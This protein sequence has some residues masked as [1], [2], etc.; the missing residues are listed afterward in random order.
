MANLFIVWHT[1]AR[2][3]ASQVPLRHAKNFFDTLVVLFSGL[4]TLRDHQRSAGD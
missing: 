3:Q 4:L 1:F 2:F